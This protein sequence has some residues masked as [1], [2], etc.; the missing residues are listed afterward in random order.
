MKIKMETPEE[1]AL[2]EAK[3]KRPVES[4]SPRENWAELNTRQR[5]TFF[6]D[7]YKLPTL[8]VICVIALVVYAV[9]GAVTKK[10][11]VLHVNLINMTYTD[12]MDE[13]L[14]SAYISAAGLAPEKNEV[15]VDASMYMSRDESSTYYQTAYGTQVKLAAVLE[16][17]DLDIVVMD[18]ESFDICSS[19]GYLLDLGSFLQENDPGLYQELS[20]RLTENTWI[21]EDNSADGYSSV[22]PEYT[23]VTEEHPYGLLVTDLPVFQ[24]ETAPDPIYLGIGATCER[25][26][27]V[28][29]YIRYLFS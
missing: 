29:S 20:G 6:W 9:Y 19:G 13:G 4:K 12:S 18:Q 24:S 1:K 11:T 3:P 27:E 7:Y 15:T 17:R 2:R 25:N 23:A 21:V 5:L 28:L 26:D 10:E 14:N 22:D 16:T 8:A